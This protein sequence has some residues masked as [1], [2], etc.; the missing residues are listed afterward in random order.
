MFVL[1]LDSTSIGLTGTLIA[2]QIP[3]IAFQK[4]NE[5]D[6]L[7]VNNYAR[8]LEIINKDDN[9]FGEIVITDFFDFSFPK[10]RLI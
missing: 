9:G 8:F 10:I 3:W 4:F 5:S 7:Y 1:H 6:L 2:P